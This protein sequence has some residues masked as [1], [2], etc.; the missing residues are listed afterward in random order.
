MTADSNHNYKKDA[1]YELED[2]QHYAS[3]NLCRNIIDFADTLVRRFDQEL[4][5]L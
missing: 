4:M 2:R 3:V 5:A 1:E